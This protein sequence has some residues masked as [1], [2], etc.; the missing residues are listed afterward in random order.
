MPRNKCC[1]SCLEQIK[2]LRD[3]VASGSAREAEHYAV[4]KVHDLG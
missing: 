3:G 4:W 2:R 1:P